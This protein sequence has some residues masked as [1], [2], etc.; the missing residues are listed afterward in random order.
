LGGGEDRKERRGRPEKGNRR[1]VPG[2]PATKA[3]DA[4]RIRKEERG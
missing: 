3:L 2:F 4:W 1:G